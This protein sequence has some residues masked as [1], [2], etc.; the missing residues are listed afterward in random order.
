MLLVALPASALVS[1]APAAD[2]N[3]NTFDGT[4][5][6][7]TLRPVE[8][9]LGASLD[10]AAAWNECATWAWNTDIPLRMRWTGSDATSGPDWLRHLG[11]G[12]AMGRHKKLVEGSSATS[13]VYTAATTQANAARAP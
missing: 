4:S 5:P 1:A 6:T 13:Y 11:S 2:P 3:P 9:V 7:L 10:P 12:A 8:F